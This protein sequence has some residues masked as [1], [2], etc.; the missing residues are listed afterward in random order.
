MSIDLTNCF[1]RNSRIHL[2]EFIGGLLAISLFNRRLL[3]EESKD[4]GS[5]PLSTKI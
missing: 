5:K 2:P 4:E 1:S 3:D